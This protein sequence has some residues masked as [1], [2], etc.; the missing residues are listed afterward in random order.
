LGKKYGVAKQHI[1]AIAL[2]K[3]RTGN[4]PAGDVDAVIASP[5][6]S[7]NIKHDYTCEQRD[8]ESQGKGCFRGF[9][10]RTDGQLAALPEGEPPQMERNMV[11]LKICSGPDCNWGHKELTNHLWHCPI[12]NAHLTSLFL[13]PECGI[14]W[15]PH[16]SSIVS[17][18]P[19]YG[20]TPE[21]GDPDYAHKFH[22]DQ[23]QYAESTLS[24]H[25]EL[26]YMSPEWIERRK[27]E[28]KRQGNISRLPAE[29]VDPDYPT[30]WGAARA[31][32]LQC[33]HVLAPGG[34][35]IWVVKDF[36]RNKKRVDFTG[37]WRALC[38]ACGFETVEV[39]RAWLVEDRG[40]QFTLGGELEERQVERKSFFRRLAERKGSPRI[41][42]EVVLITRKV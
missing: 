8:K 3:Y 20:T 38:E 1:S 32:L 35:A 21:S 9:Y 14:R 41:D 40:A 39:I 30:F 11:K 29:A 31:I 19:W 42:Y 7:V 17:S 22:G 25:N 16:I 18:P 10:G 24:L 13:C 4:M 27:Q 6:H 26:T 23:S 37:Q 15:I 33:H 2:G 28:A 5:P 36:V 12:C 34:V